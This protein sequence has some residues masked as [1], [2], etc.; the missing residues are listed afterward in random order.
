MLGKR[1]ATR[2]PKARPRKSAK[3][4]S[5]CTSKEKWQKEERWQSSHLLSMCERH[6]T[7]RSGLALATLQQ[8][9]CHGILQP[10]QMLGVF[11]SQESASSLRKRKARSN[12]SAW[13]CPSIYADVLRLFTSLAEAQPWAQVEMSVG[14]LHRKPEL[15][16]QFA[17]LGP[18]QACLG[19]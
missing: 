2:S 6:I 11:F 13:C 8:V 5:P 12:F 15:D 18:F 17:L 16:G 3:G 1:G 9:P 10:L 19:Y 14:T 4:A 7:D